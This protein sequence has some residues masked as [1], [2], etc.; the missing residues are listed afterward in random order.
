LH[1]AYCGG[2]PIALI[3]S[4]IIF[5]QEG[6]EMEET[7]NKAALFS[8]IG[9]TIIIFCNIGISSIFSI[10]VPNYIAEFGCTRA[11][12]SSAAVLST[13][14]GFV[15]SLV[16]T[17]VI[18]FLTPKWS[19]LLGTIFA[20]LYLFGLSI[21]NNLIM[22]AFAC[23]TQGVVLGLGTQAS[24]AGVISGWYG[25][26]MTSITGLVFGISSFGIALT[27]FIV[28]QMIK[29][30]SFRTM[31][32]IFAIAV[33]V[34]GVLVNL[35]LI[36]QP[37]QQKTA[38]S[39]SSSGA[40]KPQ[41][42]QIDG[43]PFAT[44]VKSPAFILFFIGIMFAATLFAGFITF[45]TSFWQSYGMEASQSASYVSLLSLFGA[46][47]AMAS[48]VIIE[49]LGTKVLMVL[50]FGGFI[51][52]MVM[53]CLWPTNPTGWFAAISVLLVAFVRP[54]PSIPSLVLPE[55]FGRKDYT[56]INSMGMAGYYAGT[57]IAVIMV[58]AIADI[59]GSFILSFIFLAV[60][61]GISFF[62]FLIAL[63]LSPY[64][65]SKII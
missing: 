59:T 47:V 56:R 1:I 60:L 50:T 21:A 4:G 11:Q 38:D 10:I 19:L 53:V 41:A 49:K 43:I 31:L 63:K 40:K 29:T 27:T 32:M 52:G 5:R 30:M 18:S 34:I 58:G 48:G 45:A 51:A 13:I 2:N 17:K 23:S 65:K 44:A 22:L 64:K 35:I 62:I 55:L 25:S 15:F 7:S 46:F 3:T 20:G 26:K 28:G 36:R 6:R 61:S 14:S 24:T 8:L 54:V 39:T 42:A 12:L 37:N 33:V 16:G 9:C 57:A